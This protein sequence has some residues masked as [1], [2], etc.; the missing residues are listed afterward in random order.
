MHLDKTM[1]DHPYVLDDSLLDKSCGLHSRT[2]HKPNPDDRRLSPKT[3]LLDSAIL[4]NLASPE[5]S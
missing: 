3:A 1:A 4:Q 5:L 2:F